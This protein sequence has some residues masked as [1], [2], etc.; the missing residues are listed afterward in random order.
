MEKMLW[1]YLA[2]HYHKSQGNF[3]WQYNICGLH[4]PNISEVPAVAPP[5][6]ADFSLSNS[7]VQWVHGAM[8]TAVFFGGVVFLLEMCGNGSGL[9]AGTG[10]AFLEIRQ[11]RCCN[12]KQKYVMGDLHCSCLKDTFKNDTADKYGVKCINRYIVRGAVLSVR[13]CWLM[14]FPQKEYPLCVL[15]IQN[16]CRCLGDRRACCCRSLCCGT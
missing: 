1:Y 13:G 4:L 6:F 11:M 12:S 8:T 7:W 14:L 5:I 3:L 2:L 15:C 10:N 9:S 16:T